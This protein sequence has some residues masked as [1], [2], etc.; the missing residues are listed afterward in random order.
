[1]KKVNKALLFTLI[2]DILIIVGG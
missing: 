2:M 1:M